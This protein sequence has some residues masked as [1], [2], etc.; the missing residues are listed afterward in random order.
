M[1]E[2]TI[3]CDT[4]TGVAR[5]VVPKD[6]CRIIFESLHNLSH[7]SI[8][9]TQRL[10]TARYVWPSIKA[11]VQKWTHTC[12]QCQKSKVQRH[13]V[14]L[15]STSP[16]LVLD[17]IMSTLTSSGPCH[18]PKDSGTYSCVS[19]DSHGG[20]K[21]YQ[22]PQSQQK[23]LDRLL[24]TAGL[25]DLGCLLRSR[26]PQFESALWAQLTR[27]LG[28][29]RIHTTAYHPIAHGLI[30][31]LHRQLKAPLPHSWALDD[32]TSHGATW[33]V[34]R[35]QGGYPLHVVLRSASLENFLLPHAFPLIHPVTFPNWNHPCNNF[36]PLPPAHPSDPL[37]WA[38]H[39]LHAPMF[40][41]AMMPPT[42]P[43]SSHMMNPTKWSS[44]LTNTL[45]L[46]S[47]VAMT[48]SLLTRWNQ[49]TWSSPYQP[50]AV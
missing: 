20:L 34:Y 10:L 44:V 1:T 23:Q 8:Q 14:T 33:G 9:A 32:L 30:E 31:R 29:Q 5:P 24:C 21:P 43:Y 37:M 3:L 17:S 28:S 40:L 39:C 7:P 6:Y 22:L 2:S 41:Y 4:S 45:S 48:L 36:T 11:D 42:D 15:L 27:L 19:T 50:L 47:R 35:T 26:G 46:T 13:T 25:L 16:H 18:L 38:Q 12:L 49:L